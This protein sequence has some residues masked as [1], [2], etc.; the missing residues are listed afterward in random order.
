MCTIMTCCRK[1][2]NCVEIVTCPLWLPFVCAANGCAKLHIKYQ[3]RRHHHNCR[4]LADRLLPHAQ[5]VQIGD[6]YMYWKHDTTIYLIQVVYGAYIDIHVASIIRETWSKGI[7]FVLGGV[8]DIKHI[9]PEYIQDL[10][11][12]HIPTNT[13]DKDTIVVKS[14][15]H[16]NI[17]NM[18]SDDV[19]NVVF[20]TGCQEETVMTVPFQEHIH[21]GVLLQ[22][23]PIGV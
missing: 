22:D 7:N 3:E 2:A 11:A 9:T 6:G 14:L 21:L 13:N 19:F 18:V 20:Q 1:V 4:V 17:G 23:E 12:T 5:T 15:C 16:I 10:E 8:F